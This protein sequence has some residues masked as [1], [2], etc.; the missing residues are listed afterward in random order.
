MVSKQQSNKI[1]KTVGERLRAARIAQNFTQGQLASPDFSVS[2]ISAIERGQIHP[3]LRALEILAVRLGLSSTQL[4]PNH[5]QQD[6]QG[7]QAVPPPEREEDEAESVFLEVQVLI[8]QKAPAEALALLEQLPT[9]RLKRQQQLQHRYLM[10]W[11]YYDAGL[12]QE[13]ETA[14]SE[15]LQIAKE[16]NDT[17]LNLRILNLLGITYATMQNYGQAIHTHQRCLTVAEDEKP[18]DQDQLFI[19]QVCLYLGQH[20][21]AIN[22]IE[23]AI[24]MFKKAQSIASTLAKPE[25]Q[26]NFYWEQSQHYSDT[27][28]YDLAALYAQKCLYLYGEQSFKAARSSLHYALGQALMMGNQERTHEYLEHALQQESV[29]QDPLA[30]ASVSMHMAQWH[31]GR[32]ELDEAYRFAQ[33][34]CTI[35]E[36]AGDSLIA[37][38]AYLTLGQIEYAQTKYEDGDRH[39]VMG[40]EMLERVESDGNQEEISRQSVRYA[41]LLEQRGKAR[42]AFAY[43]RRAFQ[44]SQK[45]GR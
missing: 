40:L 38:Q 6:E 19:S 45:S 15:A 28:A 8:R 32:K 11:V 39:F 25:A 21:M 1:G 16:L 30:L 31:F 34:A 18:Q 10:G 14:L 37:A 7:E 17:Y 43:F 20:F 24:E 23:Q 9:K 36:P 5:P 29:Q 42:E 27:K 41:E 12:L 13:S 35:S 26:Q 33:R 44:S 4:L 3:S 22:D 2:Y